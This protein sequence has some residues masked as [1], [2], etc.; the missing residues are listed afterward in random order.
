MKKNAMVLFAAMSM[1]LCADALAWRSSVPSQ[2]TDITPFPGGGFDVRPVDN[3]GI[4]GCPQ[5]RVQ[6]GMIGLTDADTRSYLALALVANASNKKL[7]F[8]VN[9]ADCYVYRI[10]LN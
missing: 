8:I 10:I 9:D 3:S 4:A 2:V 7:T 1:V 6:T 5:F